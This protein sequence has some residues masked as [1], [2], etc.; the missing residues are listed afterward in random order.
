MSETIQYQTYERKIIYAFSV[1]NKDGGLNRYKG[2]EKIGDT[3][4]NNPKI[5]AH[6][7][8]DDL[9]KV[10]E[11]R[12]KEYTRTAG[13]PYQI[14]IAR[15]A[16]TK[17]N[18]YFRDYDVHNVLKRSR[19]NK[20]DFGDGVGANEWY[21]TDV[22]TVIKAIEAVE[23][24]RSSIYS[25]VVEKNEIEFRPE[26]LEAIKQ[27]TH[28]F[29][30]KDKMLWNA[31]MRFGKTLTA[32]KLAK[33]NHYN[34]TLIITH[35]PVVSDGWFDDFN[36]IFTKQ[37]GYIYGSKTRGEKIEFLSQS[38]NP[39]IY[40]AS[41]Q[42]LR[43]SEQVG[44]KHGDKNNEI[45][46][47]QWDLVIIDEAHEGTRTGLAQNVLDMVKSTKEHI[48]KVLELSG[49]PFNILDD[50]DEEQVFTWDYVME[51]EAKQKWY[52]E[53]PN[54]LNPYGTLPKVNMYIFE[55]QN[56]FS[57]AKFI[58]IEDKA[59][60]FMEFFRVN[61]NDNFIYEE[62]V[63]SFLNEITKFNSK[64]NYPFSTE[65]FRNQLRHTLWLLPSVASCK[66]IKALLETHP[67]F[68]NYKVINIVDDGKE[69]GADRG[70]LERVRKAIT[71]HPSKTKTITLTVR[72]LTTGV[73]I[74]ELVGVM[75]LNNTTSAAT[76]LQAAF[77]AQTPFSDKD[78]GEKI[79]CYI[80]DFAP[81]RALTIMAET[82]KLNSGVGKRNTEAQKEQMKNLI[83]FLPIV[84]ESGNGMQKYNVDSL[85][86]KLKR[87]YAEKAVRT[88]FEDDSLYN[89]RL[90]T[91]TGVK[92]NRFNELKEIIGKT[93][94]EKQPLKIEINNQGLSD[95]EYEKAEKAKSKSKKD[96]T[97]EEQAA[98]DKQNEARKQ[99]QTMISILRGISI[100]IP[101]M[102]YGMDLEIDK[103]ITIDN[104]TTKIDDTSWK[105]FMPKGVSKE[106]FNEFS[107]YYD[108]EVFIEAGRIIRSRAKSY[109]SLDYISR[110][111]KI[112]ELFATFKN[113]DKE[114]VLTPWRVVNLQLAKTIG[115]LNYYDDNFKFMTDNGK[116]ARHW[117]EQE[118]T[119][120]IFSQ[121]SKILDME[122]KT[123]L[124]ALY[125]TSSMLYQQSKNLNDGIKTELNFKKQRW[126]IQQPNEEEIL[127]NILQNNIYFLANT[128]M[129]KT[130]ARRTLIGYKDLPLNILYIENLNK[131]LKTNINDAT[132]EITKGF[133]Q[134]KFDVIIGNPPYQQEPI[135]DCL[136]SLPIYDNFMDAAYAIAN[137]VTFITPA[138]FLFNAGL[139][140]KSWNA[141]MLNDSH[142]KV[143]YYTQNSDEV[144]P[145]TD[146]K[147]GVVITYRDINQKFE[148]IGGG[149]THFQELN[150]ILD[151]V[152]PDDK[153]TSIMHVQNKFNLDK[154]YK[155]FPDL[156]NRLSKNG[157]ERRL[158]SP[159]FDILPEVFL[160]KQTDECQI[161]I[162]GRKHNER[163]YKWIDKKYID[164][165]S[166][167]SKYKVI[168][169]ASNGSGA[170][171]EVLST[172]LIGPPLIGHTQ[173][174]ISLGA[175]DTEYE[176][177]AL[178]K[179]IKTKFTRAML[180]IKKIT[181]S[182]KNAD[183]WSKVPMQNFTKN[184]DI[185]WSKSISE[186]DIQLYKK[187]SLN[188]KEISFIEEKVQEM[189]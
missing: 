2:L 80:F 73:T 62:K 88:G 105:E 54:Q 135:G 118:N 74:P 41:M 175:F 162:L 117:V 86:T 144:F 124:Y 106:L 8:S 77:R 38:K 10:A 138:R 189:E 79:N 168:L 174:F 96:R 157:K 107:E 70:E 113:P 72:K 187:Y 127:N 134:M 166:N 126:E 119:N 28:A 22:K 49:T 154:L 139:T 159:V 176:A 160:D 100:R 147:G 148:K 68:K 172:P 108:A 128:P 29:K 122:T 31:K 152:N 83:N 116:N 33:D 47:I 82:A 66:A 59:F 34:K 158:I 92:L 69:D 164:P 24:G 15:L 7:N 20:K 17:N 30:K 5:N 141:K 42:D 63:N 85:L 109:D 6:D 84:G 170:I 78:L 161:K 44:G 155:D 93:N 156:N 11:E 57:D 51:Q 56:K 26:Q 46:A 173:T 181:Q 130:I 169:P 27:T 111:E 120:S 76:Y 101:L 1:P 81:D 89:D 97:P 103:D 115:G 137:K 87:V 19:I 14:D 13:L 32:L 45:F 145:N 23:D 9:K 132:K 55:L 67:V 75:F 90:L 12:I 171:G 131:K 65:D 37:D 35:R 123:G 185:D 112:A 48:T 136:Q 102:I 142:L 180:G 43:G 149:F 140:S 36:K 98:I 99:R 25:D 163:I 4:T 94:K 58:N 146:I 143:I 179:Y 182:N 150:T 39:F 53:T 133:K 184:S 110:A 71:K 60:N 16:V 21:E 114:T 125:A 91:L 153:F 167:L 50:Y 129:A 165:N 18:K 188:D 40:F 121:D 61:D 52:Q 151:K 104:F 178:L 186:I 183:T 3:T 95:E 177:Q 64:T